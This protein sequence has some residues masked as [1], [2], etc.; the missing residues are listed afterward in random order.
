MMFLLQQLKLTRMLYA[1]DL[2]LISLSG[3][4]LGRP[5][6]PYQTYL[7]TLRH[8]LGHSLEP[9]LHLLSRLSMSESTYF[10]LS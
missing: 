1:F 5:S 7:D 6:F 4:V 3:F 9:M 8:D 10:T 2:C